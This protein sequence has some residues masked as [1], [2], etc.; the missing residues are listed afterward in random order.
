MITTFN[1]FLTE[2]R[3]SWGGMKFQVSAL[4]DRKGLYLQ[5]IPD[6]KT[7]DLTSTE[8]LAERIKDRLTQKMPMLASVLNYDSSHPAAGIVFEL[9]PYDLADVVT[10]AIK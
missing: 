4:N 9:K 5:F 8:S 6:S 3:A 7:L 2:G 10:A 1:E